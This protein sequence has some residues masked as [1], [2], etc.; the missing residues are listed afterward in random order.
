[1]STETLFVL[2]SDDSLLVSDVSG[3]VQ[4]R[5]CITSARLASG[6]TSLGRRGEQNKQSNTNLDNRARAYSQK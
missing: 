2:I 1:M 3:N 6:V 5:V 4:V